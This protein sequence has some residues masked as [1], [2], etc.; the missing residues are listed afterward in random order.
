MPKL[1]KR[2]VDALKPLPGRDIVVFD[3]ELSGFGVRVKTSGRKSY[4]VQYRNAG[5]R[6]RR[7]TIA[8][9]GRLTAEEARDEAKQLLA[10]AARGQD[11]AEERHRALHAP[12][13]AQFAALYLERHAR[14]RKKT[15]IAD[16]S[17]LRRY[18][19]PAFG[20]KKV[21]LKTS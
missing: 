3:S 10:A 11:P 19:L 18:I 21:G 17:M 12:T 9:H 15:A 7:L 4:L 5:G 2:S 14:P 13:V 20:T 6:S 16:E 8:S 1:T